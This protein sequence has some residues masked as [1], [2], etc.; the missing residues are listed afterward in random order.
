MVERLIERLH[1]GKRDADQVKAAR[2][3]AG[4]AEVA[5]PNREEETVVG[6]GPKPGLMAEEE[7]A[8]R[9]QSADTAAAEVLAAVAAEK[10]GT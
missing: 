6:A 5:C 3:G 10:M 8:K 4:K 7:L 2:S 1:M 9:T